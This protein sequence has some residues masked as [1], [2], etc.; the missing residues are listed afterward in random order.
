MRH[1]IG[2]FTSAVVLSTASLLPTAVL[3]ADQYTI[4]GAFD[5]CE[6]EKFYALERGGILE[7]EEYKYFYAYRPIVIAEGRK[8]VTINDKK[9]RA[10]LHN[11]NIAKTRIDGVFEGCEIGKLYP[12]EN[13]LIFECQTYHYAYAYRPEVLII[14]V[15]G[16][17]PVVM[18]NGRKYE[19]NL[20]RRN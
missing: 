13:G 6:R 14:T 19:G 3:A 9:V 20:L 17:R 2:I 1:I 10:K 4:D 16:K 15:L 11:G 5:G 8:V 7:C 18:I 12:L